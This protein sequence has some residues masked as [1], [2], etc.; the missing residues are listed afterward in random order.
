MEFCE[1]RRVIFY[2]HPQ[3]HSLH[4]IPDLLETL[5]FPCSFF[6]SSSSFFIVSVIVWRVW[7]S[8]CY[9]NLKLSPPWEH[10][11]AWPFCE[12]LLRPIWRLKAASIPMVTNYVAEQLD[13]MHKGRLCGLLNDEPH[14]IQNCNPLCMF[15]L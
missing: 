8:F 12:D 13:N 2:A 4:I 10:P 1:V 11:L 6:C 14:T 3:E 15:T 5:C 9:T 7:F